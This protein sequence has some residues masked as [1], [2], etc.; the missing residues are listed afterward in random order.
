[1]LQYVQWGITAKY[2]LEWLMNYFA[3]W[4]VRQFKAGGIFPSVLPTFPAP[5]VNSE[6]EPEGKGWTGLVVEESTE[7]WQRKGAAA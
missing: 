4:L 1:M 6:Q 7:T 3:A 2:S 5:K